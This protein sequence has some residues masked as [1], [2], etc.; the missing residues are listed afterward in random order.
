MSLEDI[1]K[2]LR[3][4]GLE[5]VPTGG[6]S[7][8]LADFLSW[9]GENDTPVQFGGGDFPDGIAE[10]IAVNHQSNFI[11]FGDGFTNCTNVDL[12]GSAVIQLTV[13][14]TIEMLT[15][16]NAGGNTPFVCAFPAGFQELLMAGALYSA[17]PD[18]P[19]GL[20]YLDV[21]SCPNLT[22]LPP[23]PAALQALL[24]SSTPIAT[25]PTVPA[26]TVQI[27]ADD[28]GWNAAKVNSLLANLV[29]NATD[30]GTATLAGTNAAPTGQ[31]ITDKNTLIARGWTVSTH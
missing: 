24:I 8:T 12:T 15:L 31:G 11:K 1:R 5:A 9:S 4:R 16:V 27:N 6:T 20:I 7:G 10:I 22:A 28:C 21:S 13:P 25:V 23:L 14:A 2:F 26:A 18:L 30:N 19:A 17:L 29:A 3:E